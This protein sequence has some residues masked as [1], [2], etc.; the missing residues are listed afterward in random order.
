MMLIKAFLM[1]KLCQ[2]FNTFFSN[3]ASTLD[4]PNPSNYLKEEKFHSISAIMEH[5]EKHPSVSNIKN[6]N[7]E[8][9]FFSKEP[10]LKK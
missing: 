4:I 7:C 8:S 2:K 5:F 1:K 3:V 9:I 10:S 6:K